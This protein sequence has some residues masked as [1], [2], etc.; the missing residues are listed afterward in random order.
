MKRILS[1][2][3]ISLLAVSVGSCIKEDRSVCPCLVNLDFKSVN[4]KLVRKVNI[5]ISDSNGELIHVDSLDNSEFD[6]NYEI[7]LPKGHVEIVIWGNIGDNNF[8]SLDKGH[9]CT[10]C[11]R[12]PDDLYLFYNE[13]DINEE[14][15][16]INVTLHKRYHN[17][18]IHLKGLSQTDSGIEMTIKSS[19]CGYEMNGNP[20]SG[21]HI[22]MKDSICPFNIL[23]QKNTDDLVLILS[24]RNGRLLE[25]K[26]GKELTGLLDYSPG[27]DFEDI[28]LFI[29]YASPFINI[30]IE[31]WTEFSP[32]DISI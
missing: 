12:S 2:L 22:F 10:K 4:K 28:S 9:I 29:D 5:Y 3:F 23:E 27:K 7:Y 13:E 6:E 16:N 30:E 25:Y 14:E 21:D 26:L 1:I 24:D 11:N 19:V 8:V 20:L 18:K 32:G 31:E 17:V 15:K